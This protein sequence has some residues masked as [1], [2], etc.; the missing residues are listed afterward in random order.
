MERERKRKRI[1]SWYFFQRLFHASSP[2]AMDF[3]L[4]HCY[5][6]MPRT[7]RNATNNK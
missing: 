7:Q 4:E 6:L 5:Q 1:G 2:M 3:T